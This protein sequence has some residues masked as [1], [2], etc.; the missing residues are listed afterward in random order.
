MRSSPKRQDQHQEDDDDDDAA[1]ARDWHD[2]WAKTHQAP[3]ETQS[4]YQQQ[5]PG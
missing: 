5:T 3:Q 4:E 2:E 1:E